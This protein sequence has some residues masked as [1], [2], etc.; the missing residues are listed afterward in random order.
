MVNRSQHSSLFHLLDLCVPVLWNTPVLQRQYLCAN[1][2]IMRSIFWAS[3]GSLKLHRNCRRAWTRFR[4][5]NSCRSR[6][7]WRTAM[8][9]SSLHDTPR[10]TQTHAHTGRSKQKENRFSVRIA[11]LAA[12]R[13][14]WDSTN[15]I[16]TDELSELLW[17]RKLMQKEKDTISMMPDL[18][19]ILLT[20]EH[21]QLYTTLM[22]TYIHHTFNTWKCKHVKE[23][24][25][26]F[27]AD[28]LMSWWY[29]MLLASLIWCP[30]IT[31]LSK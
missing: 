3:P 23:S 29:I 12:E 13:A 31:E 11:Q 20:C 7:A 17:H 10:P 25:I 5:V 15:V 27:S 6:K 30:L 28:V 14:G 8:L 2:S 19:L 18:S 9:N 1:A 4:S 26:P 24:W 21:P 16:K 22:F